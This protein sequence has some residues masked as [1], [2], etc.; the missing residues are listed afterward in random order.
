MA[1]HL[2]ESSVSPSYA[3]NTVYSC[4]EQSFKWK[5]TMRSVKYFCDRLN[6]LQHTLLSKLTIRSAKQEFIN[7]E[8][9]YHLGVLCWPVSSGKI[10]SEIVEY[11]DEAPFSI[12]RAARKGWALMVSSTLSGPTLCPREKIS[13]W[14]CVYHV[15]EVQ[16]FCPFWLHSITKT[17]NILFVAGTVK[18]LELLLREGLKYGLIR[19]SWLSGLQRQVSFRNSQVI[20]KECSISTIVPGIRLQELL[21]LLWIK[22]K[23]EVCLLK[24]LMDLAQ[25]C[26]FFII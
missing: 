2:I 3:V 22:L 17:C 13:K 26:D 7:Q 20:K 8:V 4:N 16:R 1:F 14:L 24:D 6:I 15:G 23:T 5:V 19:K 9:A 18:W 11:V 12:N 25:P 10:D 21:E